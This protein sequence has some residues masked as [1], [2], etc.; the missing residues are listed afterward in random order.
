M[1][2]NL[3]MPLEVEA[4]FYEPCAIAW[5]GIRQ[6]GRVVE[7]DIPFTVLVILLFVWFSRADIAYRRARLPS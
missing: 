2:S 7:S 1:Y 4:E 3:I 6:K 5:A